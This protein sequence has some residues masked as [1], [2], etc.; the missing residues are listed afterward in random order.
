[1]SRADPKFHKFHVLD[2]IISLRSIAFQLTQSNDAET[3]FEFTESGAILA[4]RRR[5]EIVVISA[6]YAPGEAHVLLKEFQT[7]VDAFVRR[8]VSELCERYP[9]LERNKTLKSFLGI[10]SS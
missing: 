1:M 4:F 9:G 2:F 10:R 7:E 6:S 3:T 8:A 5:G